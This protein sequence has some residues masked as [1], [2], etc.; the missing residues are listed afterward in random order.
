[1]PP[2][3][4]FGS[5]RHGAASNVKPLHETYGYAVGDLH[6]LPRTDLAAQSLDWSCVGAFLHCGL[7]S[8]RAH[9]WRADGAKG[10][11]PSPAPCVRRKAPPRT[12]VVWRAE[13]RRNAGP[14]P[15]QCRAWSVAAGGAC[16]V[17]RRGVGECSRVWCRVS[18]VLDSTHAGI[19]E[20]A[21]GVC[22]RNDW[23]VIA[24]EPR[25][26]RNGRR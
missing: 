24:F 2:S 14:S 17:T 3:G 6:C 21:G 15:F 16:R 5:N 19:R 25:C 9:N 11:L 22:L 18:V 26:L 4:T 8:D 7:L 10:S 12:T 1:M 20:E 13:L 23:E